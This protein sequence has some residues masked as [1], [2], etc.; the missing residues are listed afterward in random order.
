MSVTPDVAIVGRPNVGKS[1]LFNRLVGRRQAIV[2]D[3]PGRHPGPHHRPRRAGRRRQHPAD[4]HRR[5]GPRGRSPGPRRAGGPGG[6]RKRP[7]A[8]GRRRPRRPDAGRR[9]RSGSRLRTPASPPCW[10]STK[11]TPTRPR[12]ASASSTG[13]GSPPSAGLRPSTASALP[14]CARRSP[15]PCRSC[16]SDEDIDAPAV[17]IVGRPN[18]GKSSLLNRIIGQSRSLVSPVAGTTRDPSTPCRARGRGVSAGGH[19]RHPSQEPG[20]RHPGRA[21]GD[22]GPAPDR[23]RAGRRAGDRRHR[24]GDLAAIWRSPAAPGTWAARWWWR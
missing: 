14:T 24:G 7:P 19:R 11:A 3:Q 21:G 23:A 22:D 15:W 6:R 10:W 18:V 13:W 1:T 12:T 20:I 8:P 4:R 9:G 17:A 16:P 2:H 5:P